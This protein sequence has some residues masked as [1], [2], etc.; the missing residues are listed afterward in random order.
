MHLTKG[1]KVSVSPTLEDT[2]YSPVTRTIYLRNELMRSTKVE[3]YAIVCHELGHF[4][5]HSS[6]YWPFR[7]SRLIGKRSFILTLW[8]EYDASKR[9]L[10]LLETI[11]IKQDVEK[12]KS[13]LVKLFLTYLIPYISLLTFIFV[14][15]YLII[16]YL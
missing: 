15:A 9:A 3:S 13:L 1:M 14:L 16:K 5:Q 6:G 12:A 4:L 11:L 8:L 2:H 10:K 7:L